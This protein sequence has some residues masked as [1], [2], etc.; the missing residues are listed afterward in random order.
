[1]VKLLI[2]WRWSWMCGSG[3][4]RIIVFEPGAM[5]SFSSDFDSRLCDHKPSTIIGSKWGCSNFRTINPK[6]EAL[7]LDGIYSTSCHTLDYRHHA[8]FPRPA[9]GTESGEGSMLPQWDTL[10]VG[11]FPLHWLT[12]EH[13]LKF[14][15]KRPESKERGIL[16]FC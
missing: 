1:M 4:Y 15:S 12:N 3:Q 14:H 8:W 7:G 10:L 9:L 6:L 2:R 16:R 13:W 5:N 11:G